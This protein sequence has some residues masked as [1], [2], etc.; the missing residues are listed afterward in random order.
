[1]S[2]LFFSTSFSC[3]HVPSITKIAS[4][5]LDMYIHEAMLHRLCSPFF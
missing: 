1:V 2:I 5:V 4:T 3:T